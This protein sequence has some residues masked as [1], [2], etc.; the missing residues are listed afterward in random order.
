VGL[1]GP[2]YSQI[3]FVFIVMLN[4]VFLCEKF[5]LILFGRIFITFMFILYF[6][7][8]LCYIIFYILFIL[9]DF[10]DGFNKY[11]L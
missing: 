6:V 3:N 9:Y 11:I 4:K 1:G 7:L 8:Y 5:C 2:C 10:G